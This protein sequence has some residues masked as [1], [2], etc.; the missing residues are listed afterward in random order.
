MP[1]MKNRDFEKLRAIVQNFTREEAAEGMKV[2]LTHFAKANRKSRSD[3]KEFAKIKIRELRAYQ[4]LNP[5]VV[6]HTIT[7]LKKLLRFLNKVEK[8]KPNPENN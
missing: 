2:I 1:T 7:G 8:L 6:K 5:P 3:L 4:D